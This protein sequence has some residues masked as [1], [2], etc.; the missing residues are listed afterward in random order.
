MEQYTGGE[1]SFDHRS[2]LGY[3]I[4]GLVLNLLMGGEGGNPRDRDR[5]DRPWPGRCPRAPG[6]RRTRLVIERWP[7]RTEEGSPE[8][9][10][11][12]VKPPDPS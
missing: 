2:S 3:S 5:V 12:G 4:A 11:K 1:V 7:G 8:M 6:L 9:G 10:D